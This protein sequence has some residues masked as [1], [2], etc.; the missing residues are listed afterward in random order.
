MS[1]PVPSPL[2]GILHLFNQNPYFVGLMMILLNI[3]GR[4]LNL[5]ITKQQEQFLQHPWIRRFLIFTVIFVATRNVWVSFWMTLILTL[6]I[7]YLFNENSAL[8]LFNSG[9]TG[10]TCSMN[11]TANTTLEIPM[12]PDENEILQ[13]LMAKAERLKV[14]P[15]ISQDVLLTDIYA[16]NMKL[17]R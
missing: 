4:F 15:I 2:D 16:A 10:S 12:T 6:L 8:C 1:L 5:D 14:K 3:G 9:A 7:G 11:A 13:R 17:L